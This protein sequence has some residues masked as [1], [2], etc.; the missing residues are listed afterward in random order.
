[1]YYIIQYTEHG[2]IK[3]KLSEEHKLDYDITDLNNRGINNYQ[4]RKNNIPY[5]EFL[6]QVNGIHMSSL[7]LDIYFANSEACLNYD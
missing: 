5:A 3:Y 1:M 2:E 4:I 6:K 7:A